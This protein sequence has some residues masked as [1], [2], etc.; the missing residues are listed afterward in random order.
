[1]KRRALLLFLLLVLSWPVIAS[2][3]NDSGGQS[4]DL[5]TI[6]VLDL[7]TAQ[8]LALAA[9]PTMEQA[10]ARVEQARARVEQAAAA[11]YPSLD[12]TAGASRTRLSDT[13]WETTGAL[14]ALY[15]QTADQTSEDYAVGLQ[16][17]WILF[18]GFQREFAE[19]QARYVH[20]ST[21]ESRRNVTRLLAAAVAEAYLNAQLAGTQVRIAG[22][23][24][25]F[26]EQQ[27]RDAQNRYDV[28]AGPWGDV[29]NIKVQLN[30]AR[31]S[32]LLSQREE[33]AALYGLA[34]LLGLPGARL[35]EHV[36]LAEL[37]REIADKGVAEKVESLI[38]EALGTRPD[39]KEL[40]LREKAAEAGVSVA[41][42]G[43]WPILLV[44]GGINGARQD[45]PGFSGDDFGNTIGLN[46]SWNLF[47]GW[48]DR[49]RR[50][51]AQQQV[52][53]TKATLRDLRNRIA[54]EVRQGVA[55]L[56][57]AREQV[58]L[59]RESVRLVEENRD[60]ARSEYEAGEASLVRL[61]EAQR[62]LTRTHSRLAQAIVA[63]HR[64]NQRLLAALG[65]EAVAASP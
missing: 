3:Q 19:E 48:A 7:E 49:A 2:G 8:R 16:A 13:A 12:L 62:D 33:E 45:D 57:A 61:N 11:W 1:M 40:K 32:L 9:N 52:R 30:S 6:E 36:R 39:V 22:A 44:A 21:E 42:A 53:E 5:S 58:V 47:S 18:N 35:P 56:E 59:Q 63:F 51:E 64:A 37:D 29:L 43:N 38:E 54:A 20:R 65:R 17:S 4:P 24:R 25:D 28:G 60:L 46:L 55:L 27:L 15:G 50:F 14:A 41:E 31:T 10:R 34:S 23:D 26:Y